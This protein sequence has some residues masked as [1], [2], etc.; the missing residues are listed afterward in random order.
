MAVGLAAAFAW[1]PVGMP[2]SGTAHA[3][4][5]GVVMPGMLGGWQWVCCGGREHG[6][7]WLGPGAHGEITGYIHDDEARRDT[8]VRRVRF[9]GDG[10]TLVRTMGP[11]CDQE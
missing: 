10:L 8:A 5:P 4:T 1:H 7:L 2:R 11:N 9:V 6:T 3:A